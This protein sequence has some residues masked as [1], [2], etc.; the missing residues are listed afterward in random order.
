MQWWLQPKGPDSVQPLD[1]QGALPAYL[2][3]EFDLSLPFRPTDFT[4]VNLAVNRVLVVQAHSESI[5]IE[6][7]EKISAQYVRELLMA[8]PGVVLA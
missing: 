1:P 2:L 6:T 4:Q 8:A 3:P 5:N 7:S